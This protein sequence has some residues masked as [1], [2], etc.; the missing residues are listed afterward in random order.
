MCIEPSQKIHSITHI[1]IGAKISAMNQHI[2]IWYFYTKM[3]SVG[4]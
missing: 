4:V 2:A 1:A 3:A